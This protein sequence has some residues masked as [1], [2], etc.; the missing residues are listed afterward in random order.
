MVLTDDATKANFAISYVADLTLTAGSDKLNTAAFGEVPLRSPSHHVFF[1]RCE[2][3]PSTV[4]WLDQVF[5]L[6]N[7]DPSRGAMIHIRDA[8][9]NAPACLAVLTGYDAQYLK[10]AY[11]ALRVAVAGGCVNG[12]RGHFAQWAHIAEEVRDRYSYFS[13]IWTLQEVL[14]SKTVVYDCD[15]ER[16]ASGDIQQLLLGWQRKK[17]SEKEI[18]AFTSSKGLDFKALATFLELCLGAVERMSL[19]SQGTP[20]KLDDPLA[21]ARILAFQD[22]SVQVRYAADARTVSAALLTLFGEDD[23]PISDCPCTT[24]C[25]SP[26]DCMAADAI[27]RRGFIVRNLR[28][29]EFAIKHGDTFCTWSGHYAPLKCTVGPRDPPAASTLWLSAVV[30]DSDAKIPELLFPENSATIG[31]P[32][33]LPVAIPQV[34]KTIKSRRE[35]STQI[36][37]DVCMVELWKEATSVLVLPFWHKLVRYLERPECIIVDTSLGC[38]AVVRKTSDTFKVVGWALN[39]TKRIAPGKEIVCEAIPDAK[40]I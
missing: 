8:Y 16:V 23:D 10:A 35:T 37:A 19:T 39:R 15:G 17:P 29:P 4:Y 38:A 25:Q 24:S 1:Q 32:F 20:A 40:L 7:P 27:A 11:N 36:A 12:C 28:G 2:D 5:I 26:L 6:T 21:I 30:T 3:D 14:M 13:R 33:C 22:L 18:Y 34:A 9:L 31:Q